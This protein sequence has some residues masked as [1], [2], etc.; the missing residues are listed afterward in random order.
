MITEQFKVRVETVRELT[1]DEL[2]YA[3]A[4]YYRT[5]PEIAKAYFK[6]LEETEGEIA[7]PFPSSCNRFPCKSLRCNAEHILN[8]FAY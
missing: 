2:V 8:G 5:N 7:C 3:A 4:H 6:Q 1:R